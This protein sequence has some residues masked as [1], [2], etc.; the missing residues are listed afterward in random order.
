MNLSDRL[1][2]ILRTPRTAAAVSGVHP[3]APGE[4]VGALP[5]DRFEHSLG[6]QWRQER[7]ARC[8]VVEHRTS[9]DGTYGARRIGE[10]A[11]CLDRVAMHAHLLASALPARPPF[12]FFDIETTGLSGGAGTYAFLVGCA[13]FGDTGEF[14]TR[15]YVLAS[16]SDERPMLEIVSGELARAGALVTFNG[17]SFDAPVLEMRYMFH[18]LQWPGA[19]LPH[20]DVLHPARLFWGAA[21]TRQTHEPERSACSLVALEQK[22]LGLGRTGDV[23][24]F[25]I[26]ARYFQFLRSGDVRPLGAVLEHN[27]LDLL[28]LAGLTVRLL[29]LVGD[30]PGEA[31][32]AREALALGR[33]YQRAGL[34]AR[35]VEAFEC[36]MAMSDSM[37]DVL[38]APIRI[39]ALRS[40]ALAARRARRYHDAAARWRQLLDIDICPRHTAREAL[41]AL[42]IHHEHHV[43]DLRAA[44]T[45]TL[46]SLDAAARTSARERTRHRLARLERK[47][48]DN[49]PNATILF[50]S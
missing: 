43:R 49:G 46:G 40:L 50:Q 48:A 17:K 42:A 41:E 24:G 20:I 12:V 33:V 47:L 15:Q 19:R 31:R 29:Q 38:A 4:A 35:A 28:T 8:L 37:G 5:G 32:D 18:R 44:R 6:A 16:H 22:V 45:F 9:P 13:G 3:T 30:G 14:L 10:M 7:H 26:P 11:S 21:G 27:R 34:E 1:R 39:D 2:G 36:A 25:E 23:P